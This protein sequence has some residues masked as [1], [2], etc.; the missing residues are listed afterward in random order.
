MAAAAPARGLRFRE[1]D[2][3]PAGLAALQRFYHERYVAEFPDPDERES[4]DNMRRYLALKAQGWYG[5]NNYHIVVAELD[6]EALGGVVFDYLAMPRAGVIEFLFVAADRRASGIGRALLD[7][8]I[9]LLR[10]DARRHG[11]RL[12]AVVAEMNDPFRLPATPDNMDPFRRAA[13]WGRWGFGVLEFPYV[14]PALSAGQQPVDG[15]LL[16]MRPF[17]RVPQSGFH[18]PW[19]ELV[20]AEYLRWAMRIEDPA[21]DRD[22]LAMADALAARPRVALVPLGRYA[23]Q[24]PT[25]G[26][27]IEPVSSPDRPPDAIAT[28]AAIARAA[29][30]VPGRVA[31]QQDFAAAFAVGDSGAARYHLWLLRAAADAP[32]EGMASFFTLPT[33]GFGGYLVLAGSLRGR[34]LL[35][36]VLARIEAHMRQDGTSAEGWFIECGTESAAVFRHVGFVEVPCDYRPPAVGGGPAG[37]APER[38]HLL[39]KPFGMRR[40]PDRLDR[41]FVFRALREI[42]CFVYAIGNPAAAACYRRVLR[43]LADGDRSGPLR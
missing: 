33:A 19:V 1:I 18:S 12:A 9:R 14:Q 36:P 30:P 13:I 4:L 22:F 29:I 26:L 40:A 23:G 37:G 16:I 25:D 5:D 41:N 20:V 17:G 34:G 10:R 15:L 38:L 39:F 35:R 2:A 27:L 21:A 3:S 24:E 28:A 42:L 6:G 11:A 31:A 32:A 7:E 43:T 8:A